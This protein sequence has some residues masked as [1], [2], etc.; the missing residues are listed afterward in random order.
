MTSRIE[1]IFWTGFTAWHGRKEKALPYY[2]LETLL[3]IQ[4]RRITAIIALAYETVPFYREFMKKE[5]LLPAD[6]RTAGDLEKLPL[7]NS[8]DLSKNPEWFYSSA[9]HE[10]KVLAL[11]TSGSSGRYK[12][13]RHDFKAMFLARA[14]GHRNR[15]VLFHFVGRS[16]GYKEVNVSR[17]GGTGPAVLQFYNDHSWVPRGIRLKRTMAFPEDTFADNIR[18]INELEPDVIIGFGSY[19]GAIYRWAWLNGIPV[20]SPKL[21]SYGGDTLQEPDRRIIEHEYRIPVI[22]RYQACEALN[23][24]FQCEM[25]KGFHISLDQIV[26]RIVDS[27]GNT[28][29]PGSSGEIVI[30]NL[31]NR[32]TV[33][34][35]YRMGDQ[36]QLFPYPCTCG[37][38]LPTFVGLRGRTDDLIVLSDGEVVHES[39]ILSR[40][41]SVPGVMQVQV[42]QQS[43]TSFVL[44]MVCAVERDTKAVSQE[45]AGIFLETIGKA[46][47]ISLKIEPVNVIPQ[48]ENGKFR[49]VVSLCSR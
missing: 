10:S 18:V 39:V 30:S 13:I 17:N 26:L 14:G 33:L 45:L 47:G 4:N 22:S 34:L 40:L 11:S 37:R 16:L 3:R 35:N 9:F 12:N 6:F 20:Y 29:P 36:G 5:K 27:E 31:I 23:I 21:I 25:G 15:M 41:Y 48:E 28:V 7:V 38:T 8:E 44:K 42:T 46:D 1:K 19:V 2:P 24:A 43:L 32:A 49:S